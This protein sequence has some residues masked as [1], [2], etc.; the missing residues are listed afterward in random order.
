MAIGVVSNGWLTLVGAPSSLAR[1]MEFSEEMN[2][3]PK[4]VADTNGAVHTEYMPSFDID[5]VLGDSAL[6][7]TQIPSKATIISPST[8]CPHH[9][10]IPRTTPKLYTI[11]VRK[12]IHHQIAY[13]IR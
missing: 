9:I 10:E 13:V 4:A 2:Q 6:L 11:V 12:A 8:V 1:L 5:R 7:D 3:A